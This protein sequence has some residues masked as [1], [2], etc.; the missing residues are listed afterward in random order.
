MLTALDGTREG[1][2][3]G[4]GRVDDGDVRELCPKHGNGLLSQI[5]RVVPTGVMRGIRVI[6][7]PAHRSLTAAEL[8]DHV[9]AGD[10]VLLQPLR[11]TFFQV[12][13]VQLRSHGRVVLHAHQFA[14]RLNEV[15]LA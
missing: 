11:R 9:L 12:R 4:K 5:R 3:V 10:A 13:R 14:E 6:R 7:V 2:L 15:L 8:H 1:R